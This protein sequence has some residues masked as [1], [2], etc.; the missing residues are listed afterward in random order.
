MDSASAPAMHWTVALIGAT[1]SGKTMLAE[2]LLHR[3]GAIPRLGS[4]EQGTTVCDHE[5]EEIARGTTLALS[6]AWLSWRVGDA[7]H[8][9]TLVDTPGHPDFVGAMDAALA[10]ADVAVVVV[11]AVDGV[12][13]GTRAAWTAA[14]AAD[15][16]CIVVVTQ[17]D[18]ARA[19]FRDVLGRLREEFGDRVWALEL[20]VGEAQ[21]FLGIA[22][23]LTEQALF[24][25]ADGRH[26]EQPLPAEL[27]EEEHRLHREVTEEIVSRDDE[28][29]EAY[30]EGS[31]PPAGEL[32]HTLAG[33]VAAREAVPV[34]VCSAATGAG[35]DH[36]LDLVCGLAPS[37]T[38]HDG[39]I[40]L[41][42]DADG[43]G[44]VEHGVAPDVAG[45]TLVHVFHTVADP[46]VGQM[47]MLKVLSG[48]VRPGDRLRN[49]TTGVE[50][51]IP[52]L[53]RLRGAEHLPV[54]ALRAGEVGAVAKLTGALSGSLLWSRTQTGARPVRLP[55]RPPVFAMS[56]QPVSQSDDT[57][58]TTALGRLV[59]EDPTLVVERSGADTILRGL[60]DTHVAVAVE[61][62]ARVLGVHVTTAAAPVAYR[63]TIARDA[64]AEGKLKKQSGGHGQ[65]AVV[66]VR[67]S[68]L[69]PGEGFEFVNSVVG[70]SVPRSYIPAV[71]KGVRDAL[72]AGGSLGHP[73]VDVRVE[74]F[75]GKSHS[76]DSSDMAFRT[77]AA[78]GVKA[79]LAEAGGILL[80][81]VSTVVVTVPTSLQGQVLTDLSGRRGRVAGTETDSDG[82][83]RVVAT[84][85]DAELTRYVLDLRALTG[86]HAELTLTPEGYEQA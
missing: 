10:V 31:E 19:S 66:M 80:E 13:A 82:R 29:L 4:I 21:A 54:D 20:P 49:A 2:A 23:V 12:T 41:G 48:V 77:A 86:G 64:S 61:R 36:V 11:S 50:D 9:I 35:V 39:R 62:L 38:G 57:K 60:G 63:E 40:V 22:D 6:L 83:T 34:M 28:Q 42:A 51:R 30:L 37:A 7:E 43:G 26:R 79:A 15:V 59:A 32:E 72:A 16:P 18:R 27:E 25:G 78:M 67:V 24:Y 70:G 68:P 14:E 85:P 81:P 1:G 73:V 53:F 46:F 3:A 76:V 58:L 84:V 47:A 75:D 52:G 55:A 69:P 5:P 45:E 56:L 8:G 33:A 17:E 44:G 71:E 65:F 74:L